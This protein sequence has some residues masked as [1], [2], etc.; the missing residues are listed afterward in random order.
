MIAADTAW[1]HAREH[2]LIPYGGTLLLIAL[3]VLALLYLVKGPLGSA[4]NNGPRAIERFTPFERAAHWTNAIT[5]CLLA[6]SGL[7][8]AF[9]PGLLPLPDM[10]PK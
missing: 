7:A 6:A 3:G 2:G 1:R 10:M 5:F 8:M 9:G 4:R